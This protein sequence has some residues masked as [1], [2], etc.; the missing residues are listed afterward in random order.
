MSNTV[1]DRC[2]DVVADRGDDPVQATAPGASRVG[3]KGAEEGATSARPAVALT[4]RLNQRPTPRAPW[5]NIVSA[6][7]S[8]GQCGQP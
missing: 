1:L 2:G 4:T 5:R 8:T 6:T 7:L 3:G